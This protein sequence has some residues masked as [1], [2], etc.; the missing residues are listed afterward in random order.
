ME[1]QLKERCKNIMMIP[2]GKMPDYPDMDKVVK[3]Q[4]LPVCLH[5]PGT[6]HPISTS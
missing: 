6:E 4:L 3:A 1:S 2:F 5:S